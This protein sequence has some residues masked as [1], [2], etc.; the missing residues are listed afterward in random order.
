MNDEGLELDI[1]TQALKANLLIL[2]KV[3]NTPVKRRRQVLIA[4]VME[5]SNLCNNV[6]EPLR[7]DSGI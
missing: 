4:I 2:E 6:L 1:L 3:M 5:L 7:K